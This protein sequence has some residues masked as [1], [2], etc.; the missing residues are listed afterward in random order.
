MRYYLDTN[1][2]IF[3]LQLRSDELSTEVSREIMD[4]SNLLF[5]S[6]VCVHELIHLFQIGKL[7]LKRNGKD[8]DINEFAQW[9]SDMGITVNPVSIKHLQELASL[10]MFD[11]HQDPNDRLIVAQAIS[12]KIP[13]VSSDRKFERYTK[14]GLKFLFNKR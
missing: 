12:D 5:T 6:T 2:L 8:A 10:P 4:Y 9:L 11:D 13:L 3:L 14:F 7:P 1:I